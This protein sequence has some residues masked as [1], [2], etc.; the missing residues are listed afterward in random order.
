MV[1]HRF[2]IENSVKTD[3]GGYD[4][5]ASFYTDVM[6]S[7]VDEVLVDFSSCQRFD[8]NL[9]AVLGAL[10]LYISQKGINVYIN[11][12]NHIGVRRTLTRN[13]FLRTFDV[14]TENEDKENFIAY[15]QFD[16]NQQN[17]F[18]KYIESELINK[19]RFPKHT[20]TAGKK[21]M[22]SIYEIYA[23]AISHGECAMVH[24]CGECLSGNASSSLDM[25]IVNCGVTIYDKVNQYMRNRKLPELN[26]CDCIIWALEEGNT[27]KN[28]PGGLGLSLI[29]E[30]IRLNEG[31]LQIVSANALFEYRN[32]KVVMHTLENNFPGTIVNMEFNPNDTDTKKYYYGDEDVVNLNNIL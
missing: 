3:C 32:D 6:S 16:I 23:N 2:H 25:T 19:Q 8:A 28:I 30:F 1:M 20:E 9:A 4:F 15:R 7:H 14:K 13:H 26:S 17:D 29:K 11:R 24:S 5:L 12:P 31:A 18:K 27:T 10:I 22:E 21:I